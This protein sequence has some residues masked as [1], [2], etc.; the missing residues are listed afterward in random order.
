MLREEILK[1]KKP[2]NP[3][4]TNSS[5]SNNLALNQTK[6]RGRSENHRFIMNDYKHPGK[7]RNTKL[8]DDTVN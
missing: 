8:L 4:D 2:Y 1:K 6:D 5:I 7:I 3:D